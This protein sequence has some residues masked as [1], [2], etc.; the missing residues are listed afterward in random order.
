MI[1]CVSFTSKQIFDATDIAESDRAAATI[2]QFHK[3]ASDFV[4]AP[5]A[6]HVHAKSI[7]ITNIVVY[8]WRAFIFVLTSW[9]VAVEHLLLV[10]QWRAQDPEPKVFLRGSLS[11]R[12]V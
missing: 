12:E 5:Y 1:I 8:L 10:P 9:L 11:N 2:V 4:F 3:Y 6:R 7:K